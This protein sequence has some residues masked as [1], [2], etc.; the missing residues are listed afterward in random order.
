MNIPVEEQARSAIISKP[1]FRSARQSRIGSLF[2]IGFLCMTTTNF[3][4][5]RGSMPV[6]KSIDMLCAMAPAVES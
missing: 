5:E 1:I 3:I 6:V 4:V 2:Q